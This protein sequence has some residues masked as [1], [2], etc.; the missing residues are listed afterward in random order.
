[1]V[2]I[3]RENGKLLSTRRI[4]ADEVAVY[5]EEGRMDAANHG[6]GRG[7]VRIVQLGPKQQ[8]LGPPKPGANR[9]AAAPPNVPVEQEYKA[10]LVRYSGTMKANNQTRVVDFFDGV[11]VIHTPVETPDQ[12]IPFDDT[13]NKLPPGVLYLRSDRMKVYSAKDANGQTRQEMIA[14]GRATVTIGDQFFGSADVIKV[15]EAKQQVTLEGV[16]GRLARARKL[17][18]GGNSGGEFSG[19]KM[20]YN[21][22]DDTINI[23]DGYSGSR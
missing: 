17:A 20:T 1:I 18:P 12:Q 14:T 6:S 10:T 11:E 23:E 9:T 19:K 3:I 5:K 8:P 7:N 16:N 4:E 2:D 13:V 15:D 22:R 21:R